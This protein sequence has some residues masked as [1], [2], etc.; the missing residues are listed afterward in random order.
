M[1]WLAVALVAVACA[2]APVSPERAA[3]LCRNEPGLADG[4]SGNVGVG[5]GSGGGKA[6]GSIVL[7][8][9]VFNP[10]DP[11]DAF[12]ACVRRKVNGEPDPTRFGITIGAST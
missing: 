5:V 7:T 11:Q 12:E 8:D 1:R 2:P 9:R 3:E 10:E 4:V 6:K